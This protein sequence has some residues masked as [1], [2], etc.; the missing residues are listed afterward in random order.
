MA[1]QAGLWM[2]VPTAS[3]QNLRESLQ[4]MPKTVARDARRELRHVGDTVI[5]EQKRILSGSLPGK[6]VKS[7][8]ELALRHY[9][10]GHTRIVTRTHYAAL[11]RDGADSGGRMRAGIAA[12]LRTRIVAGTT[13]S[14]L[15]IATTSGRMPSGK[16]WMPKTWQ[17]SRFR[18]PVFQSSAWADQAGQPY[19]FSPVIK[20]RDKMIQQMNTIIDNALKEAAS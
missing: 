12:G 14:G 6:V 16:E 9:R 11:A 7:G 10:G 13:R 15:N 18:H 4:S 19:F 3:V 20:G 2:E 8:K 1:G 17:K 5:A